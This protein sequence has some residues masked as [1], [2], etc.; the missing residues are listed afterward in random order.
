MNKNLPTNEDDEAEV[1]EILRE[2]FVGCD[3]Y[4]E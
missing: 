3:Y 4:D 1:N 2:T